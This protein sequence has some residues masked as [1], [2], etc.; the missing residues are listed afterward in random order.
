MGE[1]SRQ[2]CSK[3][4]GPGAGTGWNG[5]AGGG[6]GRED[7]PKALG[8]NNERMEL[9]IAKMSQCGREQVL[10]VSFEMLSGWRH[11]PRIRPYAKSFTA[12]IRRWRH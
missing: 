11:L 2:R 5:G 9:T 3:Y 1:C 10:D 12:Q 4:K 6:S 8:L 7:N